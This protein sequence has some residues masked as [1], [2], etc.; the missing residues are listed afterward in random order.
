MKAHNSGLAYDGDAQRRETLNKSGESHC[1]S[2]QLQWTE[3]GTE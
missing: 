3:K 2:E 1:D